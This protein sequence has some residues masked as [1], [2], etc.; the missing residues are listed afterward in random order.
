VAE[1]RSEHV[2]LETSTDEALILVGVLAAVFL[3]MKIKN[4]LPSLPPATTFRPTNPVTG[5]GD[6]LAGIAGQ[7]PA[8]GVSQAVIPA[9]DPVHDE[10]RACELDYSATGHASQRCKD[11]MAAYIT[12][13]QNVAQSPAAPGWGI[14]GS[15]W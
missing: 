8:G 9:N 13:E 12:V 10:L 2:S 1:F 15:N 5:S 3:Y 4:A 7:V 14:S 6:W 11:L